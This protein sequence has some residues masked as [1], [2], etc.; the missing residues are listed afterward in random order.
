MHVPQQS[1]QR[2]ITHIS[3]SL[4]VLCAFTLPISTSVTDIVFPLAVVL[5]LVGSSWRDR[6]PKLASP[7]AITLIIFFVLFLLG[8]TYTVAPSHDVIHRLLQI[9]CLLFSAFLITSITSDRV[10]TFMINAFLLAMVITLVLSYLKYYVLHI[11]A[12]GRLDIDNVFKDHIIQNFLM[13]MA[14]FICIYRWLNK[15]RF[16][17]VYAVL[18]V[19]M[20]FNILFMSSGRSGYFIFAALLFYTGFIYFGWRGM[21][22]TLI[23]MAL[24]GSAAFLLSHAFKTRIVSIQQNAVQYTHGKDYTSVG[25]RLQSMKN[26]YELFLQNPWIGHG[27]GSFATVYAALPAQEIGDAGLVPLSYNNYLNVAV[28]LG[29][30]GLA[31]LIFMFVLQWRFSFYLNGEWQYVTQILL[32]S[33]ILGCLANPWLSDTT[34]LHFYALFLAAGFSTWR[35]KKIASP[36]SLDPALNHSCT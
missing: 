10:R 33:M 22:V 4:L 25:I 32:I 30:V 18:I 2:W 19:L 6:W 21:L 35:A 9:A 13:V 24:L 31:F 7:V 11:P 14:A 16:R 5:S 26:A 15:C 20:T 23:A 28:E 27:T 34:E 1:W 8:A 17:W 3:N 36:Q 29:A 12:N